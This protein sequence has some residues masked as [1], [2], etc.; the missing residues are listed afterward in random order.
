MRRLTPF[1]LPLE[2]AVL[3]RRYKRFL[4]DVLL[5][6]G[7]VETV[8]CPNPGR[9]LGLDR[10][11]SPV[12]LS[13]SGNRRRK[14][15]RTWELVRVGR[16]WVCINTQVANRVVAGWLESKQLA[17]L[18]GQFRR[19]FSINGSRFD[20]LIGPRCI[21]EV[22]SVT[23]RFRGVG[24][25]P[26]SVTERGRRHVETLARLGRRYRRVLL[27]VVCRGDVRGV[28][29]ADEIDPE[30]GRALRA[31]ARRGVEVL[32]IQARFGRDGK[33]RRGPFLDVIL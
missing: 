19:E 8:H 29:P 17:G 30:Y 27:Y 6:D 22:K 7:G 25:F 33:V 32:A 3:I 14:L 18:G 24:L 20:F 28:R 31:A 23:M 26:D 11:G 1:P 4:A 13:A 15:P 5:S 10:P 12:M 2:E 21:V 16:T 9:M